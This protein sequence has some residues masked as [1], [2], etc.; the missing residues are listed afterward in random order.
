MQA[1]DKK[2]FYEQCISQLSDQ[3]ST[4]RIMMQEERGLDFDWHEQTVMI[5]RKLIGYYQIDL[6]VLD[7]KEHN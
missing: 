1:E 5:L 2:A 7:K 3:M 4:L 6:Q